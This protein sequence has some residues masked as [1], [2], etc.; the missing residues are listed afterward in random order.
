MNAWIVRSWW[1]NPDSYDWLVSYL[2]SRGLQRVTRVVILVTV[3]ALATVP[4]VLAVSPNSTTSVVARS[5]LAA[6]AAVCGALVVLWMR[7]RWPSKRQSQFFTVAAMASVSAACLAD[8]Q[9]LAGLTGCASFA[10]VGGYIAF[11]HSARLMVLNLGTALITIAVLSV[12]LAAEDALLA[13]CKSVVLVV[14]VASIPICLQA[15]LQFVGFDVL[16]ADVDPLTGLLNRRGLD[17]RMA[18]TFTATSYLGDRGLTAVMV[19]LDNFKTINDSAGHAAG[20]AVLVNVGRALLGAVRPSAAVARV[21]GEEFLVIDDVDARGAEAL[22]ERIRAA[23][24][25]TVTASIGTAHVNSAG[26]QTTESL[27]FVNFLVAVA[28]RQMYRAK[29]GGGDRCCHVVLTEPPGV[30]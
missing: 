17:R 12:R 4:A 5:A 16:N 29:H 25:P 15:L 2:H 28:D 10:A 9:P 11:F 20:D 6:V 22:A 24:S 14:A 19:D 7:R 13:A 23:I 30:H 21:G 8:A 27:T 1:A 26:A 18:E 3:A